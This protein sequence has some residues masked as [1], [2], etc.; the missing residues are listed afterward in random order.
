METKVSEV[1]FWFGFLFY[2]Y[3]LKFFCLFRAAPVAYEVPRLGVKLE[4]PLLAYQSEPC[5]IL[6]PLGGARDRTRILMDTSWVHS[7]W[8]YFLKIREMASFKRT[9]PHPHRK[10][11]QGEPKR[12]A[13]LSYCSSTPESSSSCLGCCGQGTLRSHSAQVDVWF[14]GKNKP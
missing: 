14:R 10:A 12:Q 13:F 4:L 1:L 7:H 2:F 3:F 11:S 9:L 8:F 5:Q 6:N